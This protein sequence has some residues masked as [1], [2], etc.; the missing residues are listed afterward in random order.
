MSEPVEMF[1]PICGKPVTKLK[2]IT[3]PEDKEAPC[4][5]ETYIHRGKQL[6]KILNPR[7]PSDDHRDNG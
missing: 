1:C 3:A 5:N 6:M 7:T 2:G 4:E